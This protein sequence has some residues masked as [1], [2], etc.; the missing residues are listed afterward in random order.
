[1]KSLRFG[2]AEWDSTVVTTVLR[3]AAR[4]GNTAARHGI[5]AAAIAECDRTDQNK[6]VGQVI[7]ELTDVVD[8]LLQGHPDQEAIR[9]MLETRSDIAEIT[10]GGE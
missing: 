6:F 8:V 7:G 2:D 1:M 5:L 3:L 9:M 10:G 4:T